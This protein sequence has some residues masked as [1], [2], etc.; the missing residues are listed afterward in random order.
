[1]NLIWK[2]PMFIKK[3]VAKYDLVSKWQNMRKKL[4]RCQDTLM[5]HKSI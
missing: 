5:S 4:V 2:F 3:N 1:M